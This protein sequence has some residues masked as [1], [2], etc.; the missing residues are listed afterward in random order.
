MLV[1]DRLHMARTLATRLSDMAG[2][3]TQDGE[4][5]RSQG[6]PTITLA[7]LH[8][9]GTSAG[10][11]D[12]GV[13]L[14]PEDPEAPVLWDCAAGLGRTA[15]EVAE[16]AAHMWLGTTGSAVLELMTARGEFASHYP[17][18]DPEGLPGFHVVHSPAVLF[19]T[20]PA[21][22]RDWV[23]ATPLLPALRTTLPGHLT[24]PLNGVKLL[25]GGAPGAETVEVRVNGEVASDA[26]A[27][28]AA[29]DWPRTTRPAFARA[30]LIA[31]EE[32]QS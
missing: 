8:G 20:D 31:F 13:A 18:S 26:T 15:E 19:G 16:H 6:S 25:F 32:Q 30:Y 3:W 5:V 1:L 2:T 21:P 24:A 27:A 29:L 11:V 9:D 14:D 23:S 10:H 28:L 12:I 7:D 17:E 4:T 22:L